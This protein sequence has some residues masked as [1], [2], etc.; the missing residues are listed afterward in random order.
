[1]VHN[2]LLPTA[3][4]IQGWAQKKALTDFI[5]FTFEFLE[6]YFSESFDILLLLRTYSEDFSFQNQF[7]VHCRNISALRLSEITS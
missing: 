5:L 6:P 2:W 4:F 3:S 1:M 7:L